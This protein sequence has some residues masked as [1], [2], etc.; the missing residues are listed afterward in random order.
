MNVLCSEVDAKSKN[1]IGMIPLYMYTIH[2]ILSKMCIIAYSPSFGEHYC[3]RSFCLS[4]KFHKDL[5]KR[6]VP[7]TKRQLLNIIDHLKRIKVSADRL[8]QYNFIKCNTVN[9]DV[10][11][12]TDITGNAASTTVSQGQG[13]SL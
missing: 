4:T 7:S 12:S 9:F 2:E 3:N 10:N 11:H 8:Q 5:T 6:R 13:R 1:V